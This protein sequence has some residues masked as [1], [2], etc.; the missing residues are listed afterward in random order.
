LFST[1]IVLP[2]SCQPI[3]FSAFL[4]GGVEMLIM[5]PPPPPPC[6]CLDCFTW[7]LRQG[8][9]AEPSKW[10]GGAAHA[11]PLQPAGHRPDFNV[12]LPHGVLYLPQH[13]HRR[14]HREQIREHQQIWGRVLLH[15]PQERSQ[16]PDSRSPKSP[17]PK[18]PI[19]KSPIPKSP[20]P[21]KPHPRQPAVTASESSVDPL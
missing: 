21:Q 6:N 18:S 14:R 10:R 4:P 20:I 15:H 17:I 12:H 1:H 11:L 5:L 8:E 7:C 2:S 16:S 19:P 9:L 13:G 3:R